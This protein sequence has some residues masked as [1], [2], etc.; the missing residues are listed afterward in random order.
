MILS[1][2]VILRLTSKKTKQNKYNMLAESKRS[3]YL[4]QCELIHQHHIEQNHVQ[5]AY[6]QRRSSVTSAP[7]FE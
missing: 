1:G 4:L 7:C 5:L 3:L 2:H 6:R